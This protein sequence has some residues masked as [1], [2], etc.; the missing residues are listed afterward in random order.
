MNKKLVLLLTIIMVATLVFVACDQTEEFA[1]TFD[2]IPDRA[3]AVESEYAISVAYELKFGEQ[4]PY[5][6]MTEMENLSKQRVINGAFSTRALKVGSDTEGNP[7]M[8]FDTYEVMFESANLMSV[9]FI[10]NEKM[11][12]QDESVNFMFAATKD[13]RLM[14]NALALFGRVDANPNVE[15]AYSV[16]TM[17]QEQQE[18]EART[19]NEFL[20]NLFYFT[21]EDE[22]NL[23][24]HFTYLNEKKNTVSI[25]FSEVL[26]YA[27]QENIEFFEFTK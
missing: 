3:Y 17:Y 5:P 8:V 25:L 4:V 27:T 16:F 21:G 14:M 12:A 23:T 24:I 20:T 13:G 9:R 26:E 18:M 19:F 10:A 11:N 2:N 15:A 1:G 7:G 22:Q 6:I